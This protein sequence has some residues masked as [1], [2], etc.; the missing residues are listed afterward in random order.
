MQP[1]L[2]CRLSALAVVGNT[3]HCF[4][5]QIQY[6]SVVLY[7]QTRRCKYVEK[8]D[9]TY[10]IIRDFGGFSVFQLVSQLRL[11]RRGPENLSR[12]LDTGCM[13]VYCILVHPKHIVLQLIFLS[14]LDFGH[15]LQ[16]TGYYFRVYIF[17]TTLTVDLKVRSFIGNVKCERLNLTS[18]WMMTIFH[19]LLFFIMFD[20]LC[21]VTMEF[22]GHID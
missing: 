11:L 5:I 2:F 9:V 4:A 17:Y 14:S 19:K 20:F 7:L 21:N 22:Q 18:Q 3:E 8:W 15:L 6:Q 1:Q 13:N 10:M 16:K 12:T